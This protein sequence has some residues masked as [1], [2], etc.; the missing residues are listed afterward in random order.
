MAS[1]IPLDRQFSPVPSSQEDAE[2]N[3][4]LSAWGHVKP[5]S[6][7]DMDREFRCVILAEAGAGKT[8][9]LRQRARALESLGKP[10]FFIRIEEIESDF[11]KAFEIG[12]EDQFQ[13]W[14]ESTDEA[15]F[16]LDSVDEARLEN[17]RAFEK[18]L[19]RF[20]K[21]IAKGAHR[22]HIYLSSRPYA[23]RPREDR[24]L[25]D[26][27]LFI[28]APKEGKE[29]K[30]NQQDEPQSAL[31]IYTMRHL[32]V[33]RVRR[34][35]TARSA[36]EI[37]RLV[38]EIERANLWSLAER[39][40]DL[41]GILAKWDSDKALGGRQELLRHNIDKRLRDDHN[42]DRAQRQPLNINRAKDG[43]R[44]LAAAVV[45]SGKAGLNVPDV[46]SVKPGIEA[47]SVLSDWDPKEVRALLERGIFNDIIYG[48][49]RF[50]HRDVRELLA[51][52]WFEKLLKS[53]NSRNSVEAL[54]FREQ[55]GE[56]I[57]TP[58]LRPILPWLILL[59]SDI[60][61]RALEIHPEI[62][63]ES[64]EPSKLPLPERK[65]I[66]TDIVRR[67]VSN[68]DGRSA[69]DNSAIAR[70]A[71]SDLAEDTLQL[72]EEYCDNDDAIFFLGRLVWQG[73]MANC[74][75]P[76]LT[77]AIDSSRDIYARIASARAVMT[78]G[79]IEQKESLWQ[80]LNES[81]AQIPNDLLAEVVEE[82]NAD[83]HSIK[84]LL[85][86]LDKLAPYS[87]YESSSLCHTLHEF[88]ERLPVG[89]N[90]KSIPQLLEGLKSYLD[91]Q[92]YVERRECHV[93]KEHA[94]LL[95]IA[96]N[97]IE[98]LVKAKN[99][100]ALRVTSQS[101][102]LKAPALY[103]WQGEDISVH[104]NELG[105]LVPDWPE[106][107]DALYWASIEQ[108]RSAE[109][110]DSR[111]RL[112]DDWSV[113]WLGHYWHYDTTSL[114]RLL[115]Y[116]RSR[117]LQ[118][119]R[120]IALS[121]AFRVYQQADRAEHILT[122]LKD[123]VA[124]DHVLQ[125]QLNI[126]LDPPV[127]EATRRRE[128]RQAQYHRKQKEKKRQEKQARDTWIAE[129]RAN[130]ERIH[131]PQNLKPGDF[132]NDQYF[133][134]VELNKYRTAMDRSAFT[135]WR[136]LIPEFGETIAYGYRLAAMKH[137][138]QY[139]PTLRS[140][141]KDRSSTP[142]SLI[143]AMAGL[144]MEAANSIG[145]PGDL[146]EMEVR[147]ALRYITWGLNGFPSWFERMHQAY[148]DLVEEAV[149]KELVWELDNTSSYK[150][151]HYIL[152]K[153]VYHAPWLHVSIAPVLLEWVEANPTRLNPNRQYC[154]QILVNGE[155]DSD[156]LSELASQQIVQTNNP[157]DI[158]W[159]YAL[160][161]DCDS[162]NGISELEQWLSGLDKDTATYAAQVFIT[163][164]IGDRH[165]RK[166][167]ANVGRFCTAMH[168]KSLYT[169]M[170]RHI[171]A[172]EDIDRS[173]GGVYSPKLRDDA[174]DARSKLFNL[175]SEIPGKGSYTVIR[176]L[177]NEHPDP[178]YR[179]WME[180]SANKRAEED[181]DLEPWSA[182]QISAFNTS[183]TLIPATHRQLF[184]LTVHRLQDLKNWLERGNDSPW[185]T[186]QRTNSET[187]MR[188]L[189]AGWLRQQSR[190]QYTIAQELELAN[191]QR[192]DICLH[193]TKVHSPVPI[194]LKL[195]DKNWTGPKLCE[196]LRNQLV[197]DYL[198]EESAG[199]G[200][201]LLVSQ[202]TLD[203]RWIINSRRVGLGELA[204]AL[205]CYWQ[206]IANDYPGV[207]AVEVIVIDLAMREQV[208]D[209]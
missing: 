192:M 196:R 26:E 107:N 10:S 104:K 20:A 111:K 151:M 68:T 110:S 21:G 31:T 25:M 183:Q 146:D 82:A 83:S 37:G 148:P 126:F 169:L 106:L 36:K 33:E 4:I 58:R 101:I 40:F 173:G 197:G 94:W 191:A 150:S 129:L 66:L 81:D 91:R 179:P 59:D 14:L 105:A 130:P 69:R 143:F 35:C 174:Q 153:L 112:T 165:S 49:V 113:S 46:T 167:G 79:S 34:F 60:R 117:S 12:E 198:R 175:L 6:W 76:L 63:V 115:D 9:E 51:A 30:K 114:P 187:E 61:R 108:A 52:E 56:K 11:Y 159:W 77:I 195:L 18:S 48:A 99:N 86:S 149:I 32:D 75:Y 8:E 116:M 71:N 89:D 17:P 186:W 166:G 189:I 1:H 160:R 96:I 13:T 62:A 184:E 109:S 118:D 190:D 102:L 163:T 136:A 78:C 164:L 120:L 208:C 202:S 193:N 144:E 98:R 181:G 137:W 42:S 23:W 16:Y 28:A 2:E 135:N 57:V 74:I 168:L 64:G 41:E 55:Y 201:F 72:I 47:E 39:P 3:E 44:R 194:E 158:S 128:E 124:D 50:R 185:Q 29:D 100:E 132:S 170:H 43:A 155:T 53:G 188:T 7:D 5:K 178:D 180:K 182:E 80:R 19:R 142:Y 140:E 141:G 24:R 161:V 67:I 205:N 70:I 133:L 200:V 162:V 131:N 157:D 171:R 121:T 134:M 156:K 15:W 207:E 172:K 95:S 154:L 176:Q 127:S 206:D 22:A 84:Q 139:N 88:V 199:C 87:S 90:H 97:A 147:H 38:H 93:S 203:K 27:I 123:A 125:E 119:D 65:K 92:P 45:L 122:L 209:S 73:D 177:I 152:H 145:F 54:F 85:N 138:R 204:Y 103:Y